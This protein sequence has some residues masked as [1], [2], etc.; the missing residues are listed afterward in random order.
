MCILLEKRV[1]DKA[2]QLIIDVAERLK[3]AK[4]KEE[5]DYNILLLSDLVS[6]LFKAW[7]EGKISYED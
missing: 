2:V 5:F 3:K 6:A 1:R 4:S 7:R